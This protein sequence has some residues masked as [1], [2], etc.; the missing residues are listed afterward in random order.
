[1]KRKC[2]G[3]IKETLKLDHEKLCLKTIYDDYKA[4]E[5]LKM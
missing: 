2:Q 1:M 5:C 4:R 3:D